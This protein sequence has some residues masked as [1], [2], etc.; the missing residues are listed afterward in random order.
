MKK[1]AIAS[2]NGSYVDRHFG[3]ADYFYIYE[4]SSDEYNLVETRDAVEAKQSRHSN[5]H[6]NID[7]LGDLVSDCDAVVCEKAGP[8]IAD[9]LNKK[10][11]KLF[12]ASGK[13]DA[14]LNT[15]IIKKMV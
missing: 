4:V 3:R 2:S 14:V 5:N 7:K 15:L 8:E 13:T 1:V 9:Y 10:G 6:T 12:Q 11:I